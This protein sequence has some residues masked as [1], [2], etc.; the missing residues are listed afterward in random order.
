[1]WV[2][3]ESKLN[4]QKKQ[5]NLTKTVNFDHCQRLSDISLGY[6]M[7][8]IAVKLPK[9]QNE[10]VYPKEQLDRGSTYRYQLNR[11]Q[12]SNSS[13][14]YG[15]QSVELISHYSLKSFK[16]E[17]TNA[18]QTIIS[19]SL[20]L[21]EIINKE[22]NKK[23]KENKLNLLAESESLLYNPEFETL[24][25]QYIMYGDVKFNNKDKLPYNLNYQQDSKEKIEKA[26]NH[27]KNLA[28]QFKQEKKI[29]AGID[30]GTASLEYQRL[31]ELIR[32]S[33]VDELKQLEKKIASISRIA[34]EL[35]T[36]VLAS[37]ASRNSL[38][39]LFEQIQSEKINDFKAIIALKI[40][41][42]GSGLPA[43]SEAQVDIL[44]EL[45]NSNFF[46]KSSK[47]MLKQACWLTFGSMVRELNELTIKAK[48]I[49][50]E[51]PMKF[52]EKSLKNKL[53]FYKTV[54]YKKKFFKL[55]LFNIQHI[56]F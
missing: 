6:H 32:M 12:K 10:T 48:N 26:L 52:I 30:I 17:T 41:G 1:M 24:Q 3:N 28:A 15:I 5:I 4:N 20:E 23:N 9:E 35:F 39:V 22:N 21:S 19:A 45:C 50:T 29:G 2:Y 36:D 14:E 53:N 27:L 38:K 13:M 56:H 55:K 49:R 44:L 42:R 51:T 54:S 31:I 47:F 7:E 18:M 34:V 40:I 33:S 16:S 43:I 11:D 46:E 37:A 8:D 25:K